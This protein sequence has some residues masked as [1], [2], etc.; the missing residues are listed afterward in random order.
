MLQI[1]PTSL[2]Q[3][4]SRYHVWKRS[5]WGPLKHLFLKWAKE[6]TKKLYNNIMGS[7]KL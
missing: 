3:V 1:L 4:K 6:N 2:A 5:K 7:I